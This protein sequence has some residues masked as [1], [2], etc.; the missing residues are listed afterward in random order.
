ML[1]GCMFMCVP[2]AAIGLDEI[3][4]GQQKADINHRHFL[5]E[6]P[7]ITILPSELDAPRV[8]VCVH[9]RTHLPFI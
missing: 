9:A 8:R 7:K 1:F 2:F 4:I 6:S 3:L 5:S